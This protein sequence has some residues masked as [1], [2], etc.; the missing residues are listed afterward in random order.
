MEE[1]G[2]MWVEIT[3]LNGKWQIIAVLCGNI[4]LEVLPVQ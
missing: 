4:D 1:K 2:K 3:G